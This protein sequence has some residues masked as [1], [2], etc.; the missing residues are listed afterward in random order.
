MFEPEII[1]GI[2]DNTIKNNGLFGDLLTP[3]NKAYLVQNSLVRPAQAGEILCRQNQLDRAVFFIVKGEVEVTSQSKDKITVLGKLGRGEL[4]GEV[5]ILFRI[6]R[7]ATVT[8][9]QPSVVL[10]IPTEIFADILHGNRDLQQAVIKRC[11]NRIIE[12]SLLRVPVFNKLDMQSLSELCYLASL[13][14]AEKGAVIANEGKKERSMYVICSGIAKVYVTA[15]DKNIAIA[16]L[17]PGDYF[18][19]HALFTGSAR[20]ASVAALTD[21]QLVVLEGES[22][23]SFIDYNEDV[24]F[25]I[26]QLSSQRQN[27][28]GDMRRENLRGG[29]LVEQ[30]IDQVLEMLADDN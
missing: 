28:L 13:V 7:I 18:G 5:S 15:N 6:P 22:F 10:E 30:Q 8:V 27:E 25:E 23:Q 17:Q 9:T 11:K 4:V 1:L 14:K 29:R 2:I 24:E 21:L 3:E 12:T 20:S 16:H 19:E 26:G